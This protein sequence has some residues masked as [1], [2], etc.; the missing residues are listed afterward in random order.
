MTKNLKFLPL[1]LFII[2]QFIIAKSNM[3]SDFIKM[4]IVIFIIV[5]TG[6]I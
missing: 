4:L 6:V 2:Y 3:I 5:L 1:L